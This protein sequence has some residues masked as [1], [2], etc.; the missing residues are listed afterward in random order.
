MLNDNYIFL[1]KDAECLAGA[2]YVQ[3]GDECLSPTAKV[4]FDG[5]TTKEGLKE[6]NVELT[7]KDKK[8]FYSGAVTS[9]P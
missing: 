1:L 9:K 5:K 8:F 3:L 2:P 4:S 7:V 6:Y